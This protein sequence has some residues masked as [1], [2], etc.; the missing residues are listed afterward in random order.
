MDFWTRVRLP[1]TPLE[2]HKGKVGTAYAVP[3]LIHRKESFCSRTMD[4]NS[5]TTGVIALSL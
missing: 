4:K 5:L 3:I 2:T 1:S